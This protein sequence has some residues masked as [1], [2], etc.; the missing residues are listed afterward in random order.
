MRLASY[1]AFNPDS[2]WLDKAIGI[3]TFGKY[4]HS[5]M[6]FSDGQSFSVSSR[7]G[8]SRIK[9]INFNPEHWDFVE[10][11]ISTEVESE[12]YEECATY[13][14]KYDYFGAI[15]R[16]CIFRTDK[17]FCSEAIVDL[18]RTTI[19]YSYLDIGCKYSP[20]RLHK[21]VFQY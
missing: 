12:I 17:A 2:T 18:I 20:S 5:E 1:K 16:L 6:V 13:S 21:E 3:F 9:Q 4:S 10:L 15:F 11:H 14:L 8:G 7:D 19:S